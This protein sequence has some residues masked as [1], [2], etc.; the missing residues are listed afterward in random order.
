LRSIEA[1][2]NVPELFEIGSRDSE[3]LQL[4]IRNSVIKYNRAC[5]MS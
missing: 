2:I 1:S 4:E 5:F 3:G